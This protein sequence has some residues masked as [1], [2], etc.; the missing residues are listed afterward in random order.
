MFSHPE[1]GHSNFLSQV[2]VR[3]SF[4]IILGTAHGEDTPLN[5][6]HVEGHF[7]RRNVFLVRIKIVLARTRFEFQLFVEF[8][9]HQPDYGYLGLPWFQSCV[10][11]PVRSFLYPATEHEQLCRCGWRIFLRRHSVLVTHRE[12]RKEPEIAG[13][14]IAGNDD[15]FLGEGVLKGV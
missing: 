5:R 15:V 6:H 4:W 3:S 1:V 11:G 8:L 2:L 13:D 14:G 9:G 10:F 7:R 12:R